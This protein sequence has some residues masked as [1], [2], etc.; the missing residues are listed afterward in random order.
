ML[1]Q[2]LDWYRSGGEVS[3]LQWRDVTALIRT[4]GDELDWSYVH[5][6]AERL[7]LGKLLERAR[8][9]AGD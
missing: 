1:I 5:G 8:Q 6:W 9:S 2:K 3:E 7:E 4:L